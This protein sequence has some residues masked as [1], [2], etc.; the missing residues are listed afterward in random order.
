MQLQEFDFVIEHRKGVDHGNADGMSRCGPV[1][2][3]RR[4]GRDE[5]YECVANTAS[6]VRVVTTRQAKRVAAHKGQVPERNTQS[7]EDS[8]SSQSVSNEIPLSVEDSSGE[9]NRADTDTSTEGKS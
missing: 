8:D 3:R 5:C 7:R 9:E 1:K 4:C 6:P 2:R